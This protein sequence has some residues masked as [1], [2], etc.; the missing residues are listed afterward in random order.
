MP[1]KVNLTYAITLQ[2][3]DVIKYFKSKGYRFSF[4]WFEVWQDAHHKS[5]TVAKAMRMD[6]LQTIREM[7]DKAIEDGITYDEFEHELAPKLQALGWWGKKEMFDE[8]G[9]L[10]EVQLGSPK[11]LE[12]IYY[13]NLTVAYSVGHYKFQS[14]NSDNRPYWQYKAVMDENTRITHAELNDKV[15]HY[16]HPFWQIFYP[17]NDWGCRCWVRAL[18]KAQVLSKGLTIET[19]MPDQYLF[20]P[21]EWAFNPGVKAFEPD[22]TKYDKDIVNQYKKDAKGN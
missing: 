11:R 16:Q 15:Y 19:E 18:T 13:T 5:F 17:P 10:R 12:T 2:P 8:K 6:V 4:D 1:K 22:L 9:N 21:D 20:P 14:E 7:V 3:E